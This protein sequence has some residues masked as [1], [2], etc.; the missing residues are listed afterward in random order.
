MVNRLLIAFTVLFL[1]ISNQK[2]AHSQELLTIKSVG[3]TIQVTL[4]GDIFTY[5]Y[6]FSNPP[7]NNGP[8]WSMSLQNQYVS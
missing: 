1:L 4:S 7:T 2:T 8:I 6:A 3:I 5:D